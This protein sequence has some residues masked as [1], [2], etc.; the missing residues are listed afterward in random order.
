MIPVNNQ[1]IS[2]KRN[3][4]LIGIYFLVLVIVIF[5]DIFVVFFLPQVGLGGHVAYHVIVQGDY[6]YI[7]DNEGVDIFNIAN[8]ENPTRIDEIRSPDGAFGLSIEDDYLFIASD[9]DGFEIVDVS[10]PEEALILGTY[11]DGGSIVDVKVEGHFAFTLD[12][13]TGLEILNITNPAEITKI[14]TYYINGGGIH[15]CLQNNQGIVYLA[16]TSNGLTVLN[17]TDPVSPTKL[18]TVPNTGGVIA[19]HLFEDLMFLGCHSNGIIIL[20][21][22]DP[23][24]PQRIGSFT[25]SGGEAYGVAG[26]RTHLFVAD[27]QLG[28]FSLNITE[29]SH[30]TELASCSHAVPHDVYFDGTNIYL[31]DQDRLLIILDEHL[32]PLYTGFPRDINLQLFLIGVTIVVGSSLPIYRFRKFLQLGQKES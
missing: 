25:K 19:V 3:R 29:P 21:I 30:P 24:F 11:N 16:D 18:R 32:E 4:A 2:T 8:P 31:A 17:L 9:S 26:N 6:A 27:L 12:V 23:L 14:S 5:L 22:S 20:D 7:S 10:N 13:S 15:R 28:A 1:S